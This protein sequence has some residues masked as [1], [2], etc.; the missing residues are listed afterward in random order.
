MASTM[1]SKIRSTTSS[2]FFRVIFPFSARASTNS[3]LFMS[4]PNDHQK[5]QKTRNT[6]ESLVKYQRIGFRSSWKKGGHFW[7]NRLTL[8]GISCF[9]ARHRPHSSMDRV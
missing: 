8:L 3:D 1:E 5:E 6:S 2:A 9:L 4:P 7:P